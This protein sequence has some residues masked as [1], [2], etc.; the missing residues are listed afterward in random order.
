MSSSTEDGHQTSNN[1]SQ[2]V[3]QNFPERIQGED[4]EFLE[5][6]NNYKIT[7][8][9]DSLGSLNVKFLSTLS[10][11]Q[12]VTI[13]GAASGFLAGVVV[14]PLDV[15]KTRFQAQG[16]IDSKIPASKQYKGL[17]GAFKTILR[18]EGVRGFYRGL[19]PITIGYLPTWTI[20]FTIYERAKQFYPQFFQQQF[21]VKID[22][23]T[24]FVSALTAGLVSS[25]AVNPVWVV[26]TRLMI[27]TGRSNNIPGRTYY[28]GTIDAFKTMYREEGLG[29]FYSGLV[30]SLFGLLHVGI[31]FPVYEHLKYLLRCDQ[32]SLKSGDPEF[33]LWRLI[34]ASAV[35]K[36]IAS[37]VT[38]PHE[39]LRTRM[40][41]QNLEK[42]SKK[43]E[44]K[45]LDYITRIYSK[46][47]LRGFY[48]GYGAN[49][50]RTVPAS[51][52]TLV[53]FEY[54]KTYLLEITGKSLE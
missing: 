15:L 16:A 43:S 45:L 17:I 38:Y 7:H 22:S 1:P 9:I 29:V 5:S 19:V 53:S 36:M 4:L 8:K 28:K 54:F 2:Y 27:Q 47:G 40:Q 46:E 10:A 32:K 39:I 26:K 48:A 52:V 12:L 34:A 21:D 42:Q 11:N 35:S 51:A 14:C 30:P 44:S 13:A 31:H 24:H 6:H 50:A 25:I 37:T 49:L 18:D 20:Y 23:L 33:K 41:I 3:A